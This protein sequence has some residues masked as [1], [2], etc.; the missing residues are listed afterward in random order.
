MSGCVIAATRSVAL[1]SAYSIVRHGQGRAF[2]GRP[3]ENGNSDSRNYVFQ[4]WTRPKV[5]MTLEAF[6]PNTPSLKT[7]TCCTSAP[8][9]TLSTV[10]RHH[11][12]RPRRPKPQ[13]PDG[14]LRPTRRTRHRPEGDQPGDRHINDST[15][16]VAAARQRHELTRSKA[17]R[18]L[19]ELDR[20]GTQINFEVVT[21]KAKVSRSW[22][23]TQPDLRIEIE[24][25]REAT[26]R[27]HSP[28]IPAAQRASDASL[29][30][31]LQAAIDG[32]RVLTEENKRLRR[33]LAHALGDRRAVRDG[34][35]RYIELDHNV[36]LQ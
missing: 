18:A 24:R 31:R 19:R 5:S 26:Q 1:G 32:N 28:S 35:S 15:R 13:T 12:T 27:S 8:L 2:K 16:V 34:S 11:Q 36:T 33:Q 9:P 23:Y 3:I 7:T 22:L 17:V 29:L 20:A 30:N 25:L 6:S 21:R 10:A 14:T 4:L